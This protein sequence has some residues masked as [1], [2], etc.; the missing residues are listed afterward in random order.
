MPIA[1]KVI[2]G[3]L[4]SSVKYKRRSEGK[5]R[6]SKIIAGRI[7]QIV[8]ICW[9]SIKYRLVN[10]FTIIT[11]SAYETTVITRVKIIKVWS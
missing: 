3:F 4:I 5:A 2:L 6:N 7:V 10:L 11:Y 8:S 9:A 1:F